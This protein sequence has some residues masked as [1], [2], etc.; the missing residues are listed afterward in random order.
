MFFVFNRAPISQAAAKRDERQ[1]SFDPGCRDSIANLLLIHVA[2]FNLFL[3]SLGY[4]AVPGEMRLRHENGSWASMEIL[5]SF[6]AMHPGNCGDVGK[7][8]NV[9]SATCRLHYA[10]KVRILSTTSFAP[11]CKRA[12]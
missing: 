8:A 2:R 9:E 12:K 5:R 11:Q 6:W 4:G 1:S 10:E 3:S 7:F